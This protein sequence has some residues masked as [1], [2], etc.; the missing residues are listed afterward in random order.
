MK[1]E[2]I[3]TR[4]MDENVYIYYDENAKEGIVID[5]G[6]DGEKIVSLIES[7]GINIKSILL[8]HGH[9]DHIGAALILKEKFGCTIGCHEDECDALEDVSLNLSG[10][11]G[12]EVEFEADFTLKENDEITFGNN[13]A[14]KV[15]HTP[16]HT[17][18]GVC[19]YA[20]NENMV[21]TGDT[22]FYCS[23][24]RTDFPAFSRKKGKSEIYSPE[25]KLHMLCSNIKEKLLVLPEETVVYP[26]H[27][28]KSS[29][30]FEK[31]NNPYCN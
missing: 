6:D 25:E 14:L 24:G 2:K 5:P 11:T 7:L 20:Y 28:P 8:T 21:F 16:G 3:A 29:I 9:G 10:M 31:R 19:Y 12:G 27:G 26:G 1:L 18:G 15:I 23:V 30:G 22:L 13:G 17:M 4:S